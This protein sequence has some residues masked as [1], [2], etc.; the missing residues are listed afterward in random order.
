[1]LRVIPGKVSFEI[2]ARLVVIQKSPGILRGAFDGAE[3]G[4]DERIVIGGA[5][6]SKQLRHTVI[7]TQPLDR[8]G[9]HLAAAIIDDFGPLV[10][11][12]VQDVLIRQAGRLIGIEFERNKP[13]SF[14]VERR[15][16]TVDPF[17]IYFAGFDVG[18]HDY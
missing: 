16:A 2:G 17:R 15:T 7:F 13:D 10:L 11:G 12:Q 4:F 5:G 1:M 8:F 9:F 14:Y 6:A 18:Y 3:G